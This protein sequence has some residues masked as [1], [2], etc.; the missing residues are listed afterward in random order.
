M[1]R[2]VDLSHLTVWESAVLTA[3][4]GGML[5]AALLFY[6]LT[7]KAEGKKAKQN[8]TELKNNFGGQYNG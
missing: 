5:F 3:I 7:D 2:F 8:I 6:Y 4:C 1:Y